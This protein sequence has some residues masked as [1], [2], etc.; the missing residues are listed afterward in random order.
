MVQW[1]AAFRTHIRDALAPETVLR[2][3]GSFVINY[4][5]RPIMDVTLFVWKV[6]P[7]GNPGHSSLQVGNTYMSYWPR[8]AAGKND[9]KLGQTHTAGFMSAY[10]ADVRVERKD[11][12]ARRQLIGLKTQPMLDAWDAFMANPARYNMVRHNCSTIIA[13]MLQIGSG[14][15]PSFVPKVAIDDHTQSPAS[16][17]FLRLRFFSSHIRM[18]TPD[19][20]LFYADDI[21]RQ[22]SSR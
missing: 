16:R 22:L 1:K 4:Q 10:K 13:T 5:G 21:Q 15:A 18:W 19:A 14:I 8:T 20:L 17:L 11:S 6:E 7:G 9:I 12:D 2:C 3:R